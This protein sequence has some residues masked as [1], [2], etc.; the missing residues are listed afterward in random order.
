MKLEIDLGDL[1]GIRVMCNIVKIKEPIT[2]N[3]SAR[4]KLQTACGFA[5]KPTTKKNE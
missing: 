1:V 3:L 4:I 5:I 2:L